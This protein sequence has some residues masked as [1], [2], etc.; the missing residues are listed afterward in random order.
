[1][2][3]TRINAFL[4]ELAFQCAFAERI[5]QELD[6]ALDN[7][8]NSLLIFCRLQSFLGA[9]ANISKLLFGDHTA[10][11]KIAFTAREPLRSALGVRDGDFTHARSVRNRFEHLDEDLD[12]WW[13]ASTGKNFEDCS[14]EIDGYKMTNLPEEDKFRIFNRTT[15]VLS[16]RRGHSVNVHDLMTEIGTLE[17]SLRITGVLTQYIKT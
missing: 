15:G 16:V 6:F 9:A 14:V 13:E 17:E 12:E 11:G 1:M 5:Y 8:G 10:K 3:K 4:T 7:N 2:E